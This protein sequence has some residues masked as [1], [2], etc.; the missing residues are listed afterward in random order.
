MI[1][2]NIARTFSTAAIPPAGMFIAAMLLL[3]HIEVAHI[4]VAR[5]TTWST[6]IPDHHC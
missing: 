3:D 6:N 5:A 4:E 1:A 2:V